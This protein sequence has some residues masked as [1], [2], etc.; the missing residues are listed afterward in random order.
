MPSTDTIL[1]SLRDLATALEDT[2]HEGAAEVIASAVSEIELL[3]DQVDSLKDDLADTREE[4]AL[5]QQEA[6]ADER[7]RALE[8]VLEGIEEGAR[9]ARLA[10]NLAD[11]VPTVRAYR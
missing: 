9:Y 7:L 3:A 10:C 4:L 5:A 2:G 6:G 8:T 11:P 1:D